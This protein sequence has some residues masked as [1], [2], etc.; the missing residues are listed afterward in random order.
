MKKP[1]I[2]LNGTDKDTLLEGYLTAC[3]KL[4]EA[5]EAVK[6]TCP[7]SRDY[8]IATGAFRVAVQ[9]QEERL[10]KLT[11]VMHEMEALAAH[12]VNS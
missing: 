6:A 5:I 11:A 10:E 8:N 7:H 12:V 2:H 3:D 9:E 4:R 1:Y